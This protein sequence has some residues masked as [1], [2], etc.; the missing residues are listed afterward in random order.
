M[1]YR[2]ITNNAVKLPEKWKEENYYLLLHVTY[3]ISKFN[4]PTFLVS[5]MDGTPLNGF[6]N[7]E[8]H[9]KSKMHIILWLDDQSINSKQLVPCGLM[10]SVVYHPSVSKSRGIQICACPNLKTD[11]NP[12]SMVIKRTYCLVTVLITGYQRKK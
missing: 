1:L 7:L 9:G 4:I 3:T 2:K 12:T 6:C 5:N 10:Q 8:R 11:L